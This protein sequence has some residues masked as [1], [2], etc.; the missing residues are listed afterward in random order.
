MGASD[1]AGQSGHDPTD[2]AQAFDRIE[3]LLEFPADFPLKVMGRRVEGF[4]QA[5]AELVREHLPA[6]DPATIELRTSSKGAWL[7]LTLMLRVESRV[8]LESIYRALAA[9]PAVRIVL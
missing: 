1:P 9:H 2:I 4:A 7:S 6:F 3:K 5:I 8:Q